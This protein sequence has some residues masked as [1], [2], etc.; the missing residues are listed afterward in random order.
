MNVL[1]IIDTIE[2]M[3]I[4]NIVIPIAIPIDVLNLELIMN[5]QNIIGTNS[6]SPRTNSSLAP[7]NFKTIAMIQIVKVSKN[8]NR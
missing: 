2:N 6:K 1:K 8:M 4:E 3:I 7:K 5:T